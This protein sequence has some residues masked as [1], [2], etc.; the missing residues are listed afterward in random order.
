M[1]FAK[2]FARF[3][4][5][6]DNTW[7]PSAQQT[8]ALYCRLTDFTFPRGYHGYPVNIVTNEEGTVG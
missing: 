4:E 8:S 2:Y 6:K 1:V 7:N 5:K 3:Y